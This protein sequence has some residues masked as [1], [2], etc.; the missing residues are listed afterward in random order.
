MW[1][2]F[3]DNIVFRYAQVVLLFFD[4]TLVG[5]PATPLP[6]FTP[7]RDRAARNWRPL[8]GA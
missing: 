1:V 6:T 7:C 3:F 8:H 2:S 4:I 5:E